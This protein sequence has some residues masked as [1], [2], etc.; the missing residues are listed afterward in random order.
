MGQLSERALRKQNAELL[1]GC[2]ADF[3]Q[4]LDAR[5][6]VRDALAL[7]CNALSEEPRALTH[8]ELSLEFT[9]FNTTTER[10]HCGECSG[11]F[12]GWNENFRF[13]PLCGSQITKAIHDQN[14]YDRNLRERVESAMREI[15]VNG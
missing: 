5:T 15:T 12:I 13:C 4:E 8:C 1:A 3:E 2:L 10:A 14:P 7:A 11:A 6:K 9:P